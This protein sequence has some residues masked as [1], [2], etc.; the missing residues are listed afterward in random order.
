MRSLILSAIFTI[1]L[2]VCA[3]ADISSTLWGTYPA[4]RW[5]LLP[6]MTSHLQP[7]RITEEYHEVA[8][9]EWVRHII[10][11]LNYRVSVNIKSSTLNEASYIVR[12]VTRCNLIL[13]QQAQE[14]TTRF[15]L[16]VRSMRAE[17]FLDWMCRLTNAE[18]EIRDEAIFVYMKAERK[19]FSEEEKTLEELILE[20]M[21]KEYVPPDFVA[22]SF[23]NEDF[24]D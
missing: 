4:S 24:G 22:P 15:D 8:T 21:E 19:R 6:V 1:V 12:D 13:S 5:S 2:T 20:E 18:W 11:N 9:P 17:L 7:Y 10:G 23:P 3:T 16:N 14:C